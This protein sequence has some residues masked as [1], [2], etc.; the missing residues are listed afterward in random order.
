M[1]SDEVQ[2]A[3][4]PVPE[5]AAAE[6][7][8]TPATNPDAPEIESLAYDEDDFKVRLERVFSGPMDLLLHLVR[9]HEVEIEEIEIH[10]IVHD[11][12]GHL[13]QLTDLDIESA[14]DFVVMAAT[15]MAIKSRSLLPKEELNLEEELDPKDELIQRLI[16]YRRFR[17]ASEFFELQWQ[18]RMLLRERGWSG[19]VRKSRPEPLLDMGKLTAFDLLASWSRLQREVLANRPHKIAGEGKSLRHYVESL[20]DRL[21]RNRHLSL[22]EA[23]KAEGGELRGNLIGS[24]CAVLEL[25]KL[26][27]IRM[28]QEQR[29]DDI[30][31][32][33]AVDN[34]DGIEAMLAGADF[35]D[36]PDEESFDEAE[37]VVDAL[38]AEAKAEPAEA[39]E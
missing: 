31:L 5:P 8:T 7:A 10:R 14:G 30:G 16:E 37:A 20:V 38:L 27:L 17:S 18:R 4:Q 36:E 21:K 23:A 28:D 34:L 11:Y 32:N 29:T 39:P 1:V 13:K 26:G 15:L 35:D 25:A 22:L 9:E 19:E 3:A 2:P 6:S 33:L 12:L 24:F